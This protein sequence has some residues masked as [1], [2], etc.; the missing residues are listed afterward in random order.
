MVLCPAINMRDIPYILTFC[1][2]SNL[3]NYIQGP[4]AI[5]LLQ[6]RN[7][8][9][10]GNE[11]TSVQQLSCHEQ[12]GSPDFRD[13]E[14]RACPQEQENL[15]EEKPVRSERE[16]TLIHSSVCPY[17]CSQPPPALPSHSTFSRSCP[18]PCLFP[19]QRQ[20]FISPSIWAHSP[21]ACP[22]SC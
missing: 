16:N 6:K 12:A 14:C 3:A 17:F 18:T 19:I 1:Q 21:I 9:G 13:R 4:S 5:L 10:F 8:A 7:M 15:T 22:G 2:E 20:C 11:L